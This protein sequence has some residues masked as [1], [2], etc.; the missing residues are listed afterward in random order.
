MARQITRYVCSEFWKDLGYASLWTEWSPRPSVW[1]LDFVKHSRGPANAILDNIQCNFE[2]WLPYSDLHICMTD[3]IEDDVPILPRTTFQSHLGST[4]Q[5]RPWIC[6]NCPQFPS[7][8]LFFSPNYSCLARFSI[9][10][11][12]NSYKI[13]HHANEMMQ[14]CHKW[15]NSFFVNK[16]RLL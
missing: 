4:Y 2:I 15:Q 14:F 10:H 3:Y 5:C 12:N 13:R 11:E 8:C 9:I 7:H 16:P 6:S 1:G